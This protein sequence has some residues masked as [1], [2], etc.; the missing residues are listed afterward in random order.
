MLCCLVPATAAATPSLSKAKENAKQLEQQVGALTN[1]LTQAVHQYSQATQ[2]LAVIVARVAADEREL[3]DARAQLAAA[4]QNLA[5]RAVAMYKSSPLD[6]L[7]VVLQTTSLDDLATR[8]DMM[9]ALSQQDAEILAECRQRNAQLE[10][11]QQQIVADRQEAQQLVEQVDTQRKALVASLQTHQA[12][13]KTARANVKRIAKEIAAERAAAARAAAATRGALPASIALTGIMGQYTPQTWAQTLLKNLGVPVS[14]ANVVAIVSWEMAEGGHWFN[15][16]HFN[17]LNTT[18]PEPG[19]TPMNSV[20]VQS[21]TSWAQG[22]TATIATLF[23]GN[24]A[25]VM[26]ALE[27]GNDAQAV[28]D[29]VAA[30]P[31]GTGAFLVRPL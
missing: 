15:S 9:N 19:A 10:L 14:Q 4:Q 3:A 5:E 1:Q 26:A 22:F 27:K 20:G 18:M 21:Y 13:L 6:W 31:W 11:Q 28:A 16:A 7:D 29:A 12:L 25:G 23:N 2:R 8:L 24:Y 30:S 17:P